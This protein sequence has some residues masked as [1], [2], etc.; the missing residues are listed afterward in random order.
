MKVRRRRSA[1]WIPK[2]VLATRTPESTAVV[3]SCR[4]RELDIRSYHRVIPLN[5]V[6]IG[7]SGLAM[8][9]ASQAYVDLG[10]HNLWSLNASAEYAL[11]SRVLPQDLTQALV[12]QPLWRY[13]LSSSLVP[14][15]NVSRLSHADYVLYIADPTR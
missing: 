13:I 6:D 12:G 7:E 11:S 9:G 10:W 1:A 8:A 5:Q 15:D 3:T 2:I 14:P 4:F